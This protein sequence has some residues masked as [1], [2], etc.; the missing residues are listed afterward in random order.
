MFI[1][2]HDHPTIGMGDIFYLNPVFRYNGQ[3]PANELLA[4]VNW[5][6]T[7]LF[8]F[9]TFGSMFAILWAIYRLRKIKRLRPTNNAVQP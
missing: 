4:E 1:A 9:M 2:H 5:P 8:R 3:V 6:R 7:W